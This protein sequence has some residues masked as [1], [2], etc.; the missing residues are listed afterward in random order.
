MHCWKI[1]N[2]YKQYGSPRIVLWSAIAFVLTLCVSYLTLGFIFRPSFTDHYFIVFATLFIFLY[3]IHKFIHYLTLIQ[4]RDDIELQFKKMYGY[5][6]TIH[7]QIKEILPKQVYLRTRLAP[8]IVINLVLVITMCFF[9]QFIHYGSILLAT[10]M[11]MCVID[12]LYVKNV[13]HSPKE[14]QIEE[15][16]RGFE[17]LVPPH[18]K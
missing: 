6:P 9:P 18:V 2:I 16:P 17:I 12:I 7:L 15:T 5:V 3:P 10:H 4:H 1:L 11:S 8:F 13:I 14:A